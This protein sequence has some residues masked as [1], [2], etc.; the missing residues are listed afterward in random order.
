MASIARTLAICTAL[1]AALT[2]C[3]DGGT[4][5][6]PLGGWSGHGFFACFSADGRLAF[7]D[8]R[9][10]MSNPTREWTSDG[11]V[12]HRGQVEGTWSL[13]GK[14]LVI[15]LTRDCSATCT[16]SYEPDSSLTCL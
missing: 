5:D 13:S 3:G 8:T 4:T 2:F 16:N 9:K 7:G 12:K 14:T 15:T 6:S 10:E 11:H 1:A